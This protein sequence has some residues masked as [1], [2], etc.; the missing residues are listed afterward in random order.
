MEQLLIKLTNTTIKDLERNDFNTTTT[1]TT[2]TKSYQHHQRNISDPASMI[3]DSTSDED[4]DDEQDRL[5]TCTMTKNKSSPPLLVQHSDPMDSFSTR[6]EKLDIQDYDGIKYTGKSAG[7]Q[8][9]DQ[10]LFKSKSFIPW[11]GRQDMVLQ[12]MADDQLMVVRTE[13]SPTTG[14]VGTRLD[15]GISISSSIGTNHSSSPILSNHQYDNK[16]SKSLI[17]NM[18]ELYFTHLHV[19]LPIINKSRFLQLY[20]SQSSTL[21][22]V[23]LQV[24]LAL[25]FRFASQHDQLLSNSNTTTTMAERYADYFFRKVMKRLR[26]SVRSRLCYVQAGLLATLYLDMDSSDVDSIQW[27]TL[28][29]TIRMAQDLGLHRSCEHWQLPSDEIETRHRVFYACYILDRWIGAR[30]GKP[31]TIL[32]RDFD[33]TLPSAYEV[34]Q[35][36]S[37]KKLPVY[38]AFVL[39]IK[40]SEIL[41]RVLKAFYAPSAKIANSNANLDDPMILVVFDR[42]LKHWKSLLEEPMDGIMLPRAQNVSLQIYYNTVILLLRRPF[43]SMTTTSPPTGKSS[44]DQLVTESYQVGLE[45]ANNIAQ[46]VQQSKSLSTNIHN[47]DISASMHFFPTCYVY[48]MFLSSLVHFAIVLQDRSISDNRNALLASIS[49][50]QSLHYLS[51]SRRALEILNMLVTIYELKDDGDDDH[52]H[53]TFIKQ[54]YTQEQEHQRMFT[55][56]F[57]EPTSSLTYGQDNDSILS[58]QQHHHHQQQQQHNTDYHH[59]QEEHSFNIASQPTTATSFK[60]GEMPKSHWF[61]RYVNTSVVGGVPAE[62]QHEVENDLS[63]QHQPTNTSSTTIVPSYV[64]SANTTNSTVTTSVGTPIPSHHHHHH[65]DPLLYTQSYLPSSTQ[66]QTNTMDDPTFVTSTSTTNTPFTKSHQPHLTSTL[67]SPQ[68]SSPTDLALSSPSPSPASLTSTLHRPFAPNTV[69]Q[70]QQQQSSSYGPISSMLHSPPPPSSSLMPAMIHQ[71]HPPQNQNTV[72]P[73]NLNWHDWQYYMN[74]QH[75]PSLT[76]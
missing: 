7:L 27:H 1:T 33:T 64:Y 74:Q 42:R 25:S 26:D 31:L 3:S 28:G 15:V 19:V 21:P 54:E 40:L 52:L 34:D 55:N 72:S 24:I 45:A 44:S 11:P 13:K 63:H 59:Q 43:L 35:N 60:Q 53:H 70:Q 73:A 6:L 17:D 30:A 38:R 58:L 16:P 10:D 41:G 69:M 50:I 48:A 62:I 23:L 56:H 12:M 46:L 39:W 32:D 49:L 68:K 47:S 75:H 51:A 36:D 8:L 22:K 71:Q 57:Y 76:K 14:K 2:T 18:I 5:S 61:Q 67:S 65:P 66:T 20:H 9:I 4:E 29:K 37:N